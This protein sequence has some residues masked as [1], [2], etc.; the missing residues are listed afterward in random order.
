M[1]L[2]D[3]R[4]TRLFLDF[5]QAHNRIQLMIPNRP[6]GDTWLTSPDYPNTPPPHSECVWVVHAP[7]GKSVQFDFHERMDLA[8][9]VRGVCSRYDNQSIKDTM[10]EFSYVLLVFASDQSHRCEIVMSKSCWVVFFLMGMKSTPGTLHSK[11]YSCQ[12]VN[13]KKLCP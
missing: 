5:K 11:A 9:P 8:Q 4:R 10:V 3:T 7:R 1:K 2:A 6:Q 12:K 13:T